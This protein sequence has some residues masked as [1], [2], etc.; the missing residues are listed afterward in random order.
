MSM[1]DQLTIPVTRPLVLLSYKSA[2]FI[3]LLAVLNSTSFASEPI[4]GSN[5]MPRPVKV[6]ATRALEAQLALWDRQ[7]RKATRRCN[8]EAA[9]ARE[10]PS[11][12]GIYEITYKVL[13]ETP[14]MFSVRV[15]MDIYCGGAHPE[16]AHGGMMFDFNSGQ[17]LNPF[18]MFA[19]ATEREYVYT[20][21]PAVREIV[22]HVMLAKLGKN[23]IAQD[24][25]P[26][27]KDERFDQLDST[28][29]FLGQDGLHIMY[30]AARVVQYCFSEV[31]LTYG[32]MQTL[33]E[34]P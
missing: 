29:A 18:Q 25:I 4:N 21:K 22:R 13:L 6:R 24:C 12:K 32:Q 16:E 1:I 5:R 23:Q 27:L 20:L 31:V 9:D 14:K 33:L 17:H 10:Q 15:D 7:H 19:I 8:Q 11:L 26:I 30:P 28:N 3:A 2:F 34:A